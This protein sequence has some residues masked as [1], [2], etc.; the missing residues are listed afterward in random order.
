MGRMAMAANMAQ[1]RPIST[2]CGFP[3]LDRIAFWTVDPG[4]SA[5]AF[6]FLDLGHVDARLAKPLNQL[7]EAIDAKVDHPLLVGGEVIGVS[8]EWREDGGSRLLLPHPIIAA[9]HTEM[10]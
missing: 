10:L 9:A 7:V 1:M 6:H 5:D 4:K 3:K 2:C 8:R